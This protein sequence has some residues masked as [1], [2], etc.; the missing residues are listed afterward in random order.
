MTQRMH[1]PPPKDFS[2]GHG[3]GYGPVAAPSEPIAT[4]RPAPHIIYTGHPP[5]HIMRTAP[6]PMS[7]E[8]SYAYAYPN[9]NA[10]SV[11]K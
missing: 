7:S 1:G 10:I 9:S 11:I 8:P 4:A 3:Q 2:F 5:I 6:R